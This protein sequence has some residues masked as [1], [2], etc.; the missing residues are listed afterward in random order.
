MSVSGESSAGGALATATAVLVIAGS[1]GLTVVDAVFASP[2]VAFGFAVDGSANGCG[3]LDDE[4]VKAAF[5]SPIG[6]LGFS[7]VAELAG[8]EIGTISTG[9][10][11]AGCGS[12][13]AFS[14]A[15]G[16]LGSRMTRAS[17]AARVAFNPK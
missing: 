13:F 3:V 7:M 11:V 17:L 14:E 2:V 1:G 10:S 5:P 12:A 4:A 15:A 9:F 8:T 16:A 6:A